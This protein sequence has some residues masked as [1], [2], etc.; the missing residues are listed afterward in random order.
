MEELRR[1]AGRRW[2]EEGSSVHVHGSVVSCV[3]LEGLWQHL[4]SAEGVVCRWGWSRLDLLVSDSIAAVIW[5]VPR[6][7]KKRF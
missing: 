7:G 5:C 3:Q 6:N 4:N 1:P 2:F